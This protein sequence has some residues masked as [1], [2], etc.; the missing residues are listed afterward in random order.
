MKRHEASLIKR[1]IQNDPTASFSHIQNRLASKIIERMIRS[2]ESKLNLKD[3][4]DT[5]R[6]R[7]AKVL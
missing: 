2:R 4:D 1:T 7:R 6:V 5:R 3:S